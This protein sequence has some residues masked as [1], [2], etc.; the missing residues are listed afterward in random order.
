MPEGFESKVKVSGRVVRSFSQVHEGHSKAM[1]ALE[2]ERDLSSY[3]KKGD[4]AFQFIPPA[5]C[6]LSLF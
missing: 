2:F 3:F 6:S 5:A 4:G 1:V